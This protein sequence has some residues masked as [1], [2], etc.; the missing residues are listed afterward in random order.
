MKKIIIALIAVTVLVSCEDLTELNTNPKRTDLVPAGALLASAQKSFVDAISSPNVNL[1][2]FRLL[3]QQ[4]TETTY[5]DESNYDLT[6]RNIP[7]GWWFSM[8]RDVLRDLKEAKK[9]A[10]AD[11][12]I[13]PA[14]LKNDQAIAE[15]MEV[16]AWSILVDTFGDV[17][18]SQALRVSGSADDIMQPQYDKAADIYL[19]LIARLST[20][21]TNLDA[22]NN[23][24]GSS[25]LIYEGDVLSWKRFGNSL[26]LKLGMTLADVNPVLA[27]ATVEAAVT[28]GVISSND[29]N[30]VLYYKPAP[31]NTNPI[32]VNLIQS[33]RKDFVAANTL[34]DVMNSVSDPRRPIY[35]TVDANGMYKGGEY[36]ASNNYATYSKPGDLVDNSDAPASLMTYSEVEFY[37]AE[38]NERGFAV[39]GTAAEHY[40]NAVKASLEEWGVKDADITTFLARPDVAYG[41][42]PGTFRQKIGKQKWIALYNRGFEAWTE[43]RRLD[44]PT[45][46]APPDAVSDIP[47]RYTYPVSEQNLNQ[48]NYDAVVSRIGEDEVSTPVF[49]D[50]Y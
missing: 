42:A 38:A 31:P 33:G 26:K 21:V 46:V 11:A 22:T 6:T 23:S 29:Y 20:A 8:Y 35:F 32:W 50:I 9:L 13:S 1:N 44:A 41:T 14:E 16:Y 47:L 25:D 36:G 17:P 12:H 30:A 2:I 48:I 3:A 49:W 37:L 28:S 7:E 40:T 39:A 24:W 4:W 27:K 15:I 5:T 18:Y 10:A 45:L 43:W 19:D 34:V